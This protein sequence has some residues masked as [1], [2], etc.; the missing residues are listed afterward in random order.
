VRSAPTAQPESQREESA[1][2]ARLQPVRINGDPNQLTTVIDNL[3]SNAIKYTRRAAE[4]PFLAADE[5]QVTLEVADNGPGI[6]PDERG[7]V[8][9]PFYRGRAPYVGTSGQRLGHHR[10]AVVEAHHGRIE[11]SD[12]PLGQGACVRAVPLSRAA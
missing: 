9:E 11:F 8:F 5:D 3:L 10:Q 1:A 2:D 12:S 4:S 7:R 6:D